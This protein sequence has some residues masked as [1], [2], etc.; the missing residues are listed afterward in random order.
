MQINAQEIP[1]KMITHCQCGAQLAW[2][3]YRLFA[4]TV[5]VTAPLQWLLIN[6]TY[7]SYKLRQTMMMS[8]L[9]LLLLLLGSTL[10]FQL[11][12][13]IIIWASFSIGRAMR[14]QQLKLSWAG[15]SRA[16][17]WSVSRDRTP[18]SHWTW[19][20]VRLKPRYDL[21][22]RCFICFSCLCK[23][24]YRSHFKRCSFICMQC[25]DQCVCVCVWVYVWV[26]FTPRQVL[27]HCEIKVDRTRLVWATSSKKT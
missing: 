15:Q 7:L 25:V 13:I 10:T 17:C 24:N 11:K 22:S 21:R 14:Q 9:L 26:D 16:C 8:P 6:R 23:T 3:I 2:V 19:L 12:Q 27:E 5:A 18:I 4:V 1:L 20:W